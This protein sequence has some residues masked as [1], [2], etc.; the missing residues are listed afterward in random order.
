M[1]FFADFL[2]DYFIEAEEH[3]G[4]VR[5]DLLTLES[6]VNQPKIDSALLNELFRHFHSLKGLS[7]MV[8]FR[9]A[10]DLAHQM[11]SY[12]R[13][14]RQENIQLTTE[15]LNALFEATKVLETVIASHQSGNGNVDV[16][17]VKQQLAAAISSHSLPTSDETLPLKTFDLKPPEQDQLER[18]IEQ[19][20][21][22]WYFTF[23]PSAELASQGIRVNV[24]RD[25]LE[26]IGELIYSAPCMGNAGQISFDFL[27][28]TNSSEET[29]AEWK[30]DGLTWQLYS[31]KTPKNAEQSANEETEI[32]QTIATAFPQTH[33][34]NVVRIELP[35][36]DE[37][38]QMVGELVISRSRLESQLKQLKGQIPASQLR[39]LTELNSTLQRQ[40]RDL[41]QGVTRARLVPIREIFRRMQFVVRELIR[42]TDKQVNL[43][44]HGEDTELD[45]FMVEQMADPLLHLVRNAVSHGI[46]AESERLAK[47]K[48]AIATIRLSAATVGEMV[49][50]EIEDDGRGID[51][52]KV[53]AKGR[54]QSEI[55]PEDND[56][57][58]LEILCSP[59]FST[60]E[61]ADLAS[62]R[63]VG[64]A[65]VKNTVE[66]LGGSLSLDTQ[67]GEYTRFTIHL[68]L[69]LAIAD[70][71][72]IQVRSQT[73]AIPLSAVQE[74]IEVNP[75]AIT[76]LE[77]NELL[78][79]RD[80]I[81]PLLRLSSLF[82]LNATLPSVDTSNRAVI[83]G[84]GMKAVA[85][86]VDH[87]LGKQ[88]I[89]VRPLNDPLVQVK[90]IAGATELGDGQV[91]LILN[92]ATLLK[93]E[94]N[95]SQQISTM[96]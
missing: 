75:K 79:E 76:S 86:L 52:E 62:G 22:I 38:M 32:P 64:M 6:Y 17:S 24:I 7:G 51:V 25:R 94:G 67:A 12:L 34:S 87:I 9:D 85:L 44:T 53:M 60:K 48:A 13:S 39:S 10:E 49:R 93:F 23:C 61:E 2:D 21:S 47:G 82:Q 92:V 72:I 63:G 66:S 4:F 69:T 77:N 80:R 89:V 46:E 11:E 42:D 1:N 14:L 83:I 78:S 55:D 15:G 54:S 19:G 29:F 96:N 41:R 40:L 16:S 3:L 37:L 73:F 45:K 27:V 36:L 33:T 81:F 58:L 43:E 26:T 18:A 84:H 74:V 28:A 20:F 57:A 90:G 30:N 8:G 88:E 65:I 68:P 35:K 95:N 31:P 70:A 59:G 71:L 50:I 5:Q 91:V 56:T